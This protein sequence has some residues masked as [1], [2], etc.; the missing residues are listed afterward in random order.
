[1]RLL[2]PG[3][4][5][6]SRSCAAWSARCSPSPACSPARP[7]RQRAHYAPSTPLALA[8]SDEIEELAAE[9][10]GRGLRIAVLAQRAPLRAHQFVT[11]INAGY[12]PDA[13]AHDLYAHLRALD[14]SGCARILVQE[15]PER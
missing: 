15:V 12:V 6:A 4:I 10:S 11:W 7:G 5:T 13:Y 3:S 2:R 9:L 1:V 14:K 8:S